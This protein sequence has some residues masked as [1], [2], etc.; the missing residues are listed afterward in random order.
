MNLKLL[1]IL[2]CFFL[3][4]FQGKS[5]NTIKVRKIAKIEGLYKNTQNINNLPT[6]LYF[7]EEG[8]VYYTFSKKL[9]DKRALVTFTLC[10]IDSSC[11][12]YSKSNYEFKKGHIRFTT[13]E[14]IERKYFI[15]YD[16]QLTNN[17]KDLSIRKEETNELIIVNKYTL[18]KP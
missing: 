12:D 9:K 15:I 11:N 7:K 1:F 18:I 8:L 17:G 5:Q 4:Y 13:S 3:C 6:Y 16:G 14:N 2:N 10:A